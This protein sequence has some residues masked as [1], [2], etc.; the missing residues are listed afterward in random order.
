MKAQTSF[1]CF[2]REIWRSGRLS[3]RC[4]NPFCSEIFIHKS[5]QSSDDDLQEICTCLCGWPLHKTEQKRRVHPRPEAT[6]CPAIPPG[7]GRE[8]LGWYRLQGHTEAKFISENQAPLPS[9]APQ[10]PSSAVF[11]GKTE[12]TVF[13]FNTALY[14]TQYLGAS[15]APSAQLERKHTLAQ[16]CVL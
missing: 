9:Q 13:L 1:Y 12:V 5:H 15:I 6:E 11:P 7:Q 8:R 16:E 10:E 14:C 2:K 4:G 3:P